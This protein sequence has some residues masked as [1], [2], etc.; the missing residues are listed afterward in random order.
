V[1]ALFV[2]QGLGTNGTL[3][4]AIPETV[5]QG[6]APVVGIRLPVIENSQK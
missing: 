2:G 6:Y 4:K 3:S 1:R 5:Q